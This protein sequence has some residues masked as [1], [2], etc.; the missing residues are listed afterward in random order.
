M[1]N[2]NG[3]TNYLCNFLSPYP[4][5]TFFNNQGD[6]Q[7]SIG[8]LYVFPKNQDVCMGIDIAAAPSCTGVRLPPPPPPIISVQLELQVARSSP[9]EP[10]QKQTGPRNLG[11]IRCESHRKP[12]EQ[13]GKKIYCH[14]TEKADGSLM[15]QIFNGISIN[16]LFILGPSFILLIRNC[17]RIERA[18][19]KR[20]FKFTL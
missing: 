18:F 15:E 11:K 4:D 17:G 10:L 1:Q 14:L 3:Q 5:E 2:I 16:H 20:N 6:N 9:Y 19:D 7:S 13:G 12:S 8:H